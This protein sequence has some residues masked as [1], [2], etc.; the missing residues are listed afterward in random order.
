[1]IHEALIIYCL[2]VARAPRWSLT[3]KINIYVIDLHTYMLV[4]IDPLVRIRNRNIHFIK[5]KKH[6]Q[7]HRYRLN[8]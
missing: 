4:I 2:M 7:E 6:T 5:L 3:R 8:M 1:M